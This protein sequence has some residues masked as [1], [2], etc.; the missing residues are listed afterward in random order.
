MK[1][2]PAWSRRVRISSSSTPQERRGHHPS[3]LTQIIFEQEGK[4]GQSLLPIA[5]L[6]QLI[7]FY[8]DTADAGAKLSRILHRQADQRAKQIPRQGR[9][10]LW[11]AGERASFG[12]L[13]EQARK[14]MALFNQALSMFTPFV[15][16]LAPGGEAA[17]K[18]APEPAP[19][20]D[21]DEMKRQLDEL[22]C[23]NASRVWRRRRSKRS[24]AMPKEAP[25][26]DQAGGPHPAAPTQSERT[27]SPARRRSRPAS[28]APNS[29]RSATKALAQRIAG[30]PP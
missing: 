1:T 21:L 30:A 20:S 12:S 5:F 26:R 29:P 7:R 27:Q 9:R 2:S 23:K 6:R 18:P 4:G 13:E 3:V 19:R 17:P 16:P 8:G 15:A 11:L 10:R 22:S 25:F 28:I 14:N 24:R